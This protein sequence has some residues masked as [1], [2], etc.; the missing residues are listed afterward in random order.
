[1]CVRSGRIT[2]LAATDRLVAAGTT[3]PD[4]P[5]LLYDVAGNH[6]IRTI[7]GEKVSGWYWF[8]ERGLVLAEVSPA[9]NGTR[10]E[11]TLIDMS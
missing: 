11:C 5:V 9:E 6:L 10:Y 8:T 3:D 7:E 4:T 1:M 2:D